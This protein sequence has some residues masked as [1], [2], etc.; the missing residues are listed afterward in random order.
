MLD[1]GPI[2]LP[3]ERLRDQFAACHFLRRI[4]T[5]DT[6]WDEATTLTHIHF[7]ALP[8]PSSGPD[9]KKAELEALR[10]FVLLWN[11]VDDGY[12]MV[13]T[14]TGGCCPSVG[15]RIIAQLEIAVPAD[16]SDAASIE[17]YMLETLGRILMTDDDDAPG[18]WELAHSGEHLPINEIRVN[19]PQR[20]PAKERRELGDFCL[21]ELQID[22]GRSG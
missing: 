20:V 6:P 19:G 7:A 13:S 12:R 10:P 1:R 9:Y 14:S 22:W 17:V 5:P 18:L 3:L 16:L 21:F 15:G 8:T 2:V 11:D 4:A